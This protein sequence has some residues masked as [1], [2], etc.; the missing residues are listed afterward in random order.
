MAKMK[1]QE[2]HMMQLQSKMMWQQMR[3]SFLWFIP[4]ILVWYVFLPQI[5]AMNTIVA[6]IPWLDGQLELTVPLWYLLCSFFA[7]AL[8]TRLFGLGLGGD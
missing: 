5:L 7:G 3:T 8:F 1:K 4:L 6:Y 2:R